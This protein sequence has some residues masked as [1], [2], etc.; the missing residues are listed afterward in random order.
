METRANYLLIG[1]FSLLAILGTL[2]FFIWLA[3]V[4]IDRQYKTY[5]ILF[6]DVSGLDPSGDVLFN[7]I[8]VG[9]VIGL[10]IY[11]KD[12]SKVFATIEVD[13]ATPVRADTVAQLQSQGVTGVAY[14]SLSGG[15]PSAPPPVAEENGLPIIPSRR[16]TVQTLVEDAPDLLAEATELLEQFKTLIGPQNQAHVTNILRNLDTSSQRLDEAL[17]DFSQI[18]GTVGEA[19]SQIT[20]FTDRLDSIAEAVN[21]TL[22]RADGALSAAEGAFASAETALDAAGAPI[23]TAGRV[24]L[25]VESILAEQVPAIV[26]QVERTIA[27]T[28]AAIADLKTRSGTA[29]DGYTRTAALLNDRLTELETTLSEANTAF[30]AVTEASDGFD[31][32][33]SGDGTLLVS[34]ARGVLADAKSAIAIIET[35]VTDDVPPVIADIRQAV[36][37]ASAT[38]DRVAEDLTDLTG[39]FDPLAA[40]TQSALQSAT[41]L[42]KRAERSLDIFDTTL[43]GSQGTLRSAETAFDAAT[44]VLNTDIEPVLS[45]L[46]QASDR[47]STAVEAVS[48][49]VPAVTADLRGL[50]NRTD[51]VVARIQG[52]VNASAPGIRDFA[53]QGLPE[54]TR[55]GAE[56]RALVST[57]DALARRLER[58]PARFFLDDRVPDY[59]R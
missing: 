4:Q 10:R 55:L 41:A 6:E 51:T 16:S 32:L 9:T 21:A 54:L 33:V 19:T 27:E 52:A 30:T 43:T 28:N 26:A 35:V 59:R 11:E 46:R 1:I 57:L 50:I 24:S 49:D 44:D 18:T 8:S 2:G 53:T 48:R 3:S 12:P 40:E 5:G 42:L 20:R 22:E 38:V 17:N 14:V 36:A 39:R 47:I 25:Q 37:T 56:A 23:E 13:S 58:D 7:G 34:E 29:I 15:T 31:A 45:D